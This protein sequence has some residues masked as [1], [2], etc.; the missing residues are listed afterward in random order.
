[1]RAGK[2]RHQITIQKSTGTQNT[3][4]ETVS[5]WVDVAC[6]RASVEPLSGREMWTARQID[7]SVTHKV[8]LRADASLVITPKM[9]VVFKGRVFDI[10]FSGNPDEATREFNLLCTEAV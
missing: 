3:N 8:T 2:L 1:M 5:V 9:R 7:A 10:N 6:R 4:G